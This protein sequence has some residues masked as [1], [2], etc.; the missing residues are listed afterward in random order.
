MHI[1]VGSLHIPSHHITCQGEK[2]I[3]AVAE[4]CRR[5]ERHE[6]I[7]VRRKMPQALRSAYKKLLI[8]HHY[9]TGKQHLQNPHG[10]RIMLKSCRAGPVPHHDSHAEI[11]EYSKENHRCCKPPLKQGSFSVC[12]HIVIGCSF[13]RL[14]SSC[15]EASFRRMTALC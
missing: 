11:H 4:G 15:T 10:C 2:S 7:H 5:T 13:R 12:E 6:G 8:D 9:Y 1:A 14:P 3:Y